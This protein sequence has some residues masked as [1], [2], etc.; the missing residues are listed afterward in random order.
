MLAL[1]TLALVAFAWVPVLTGNPRHS[2]FGA[3]SLSGFAAIAAVAG[4]RAVAALV[5]LT[6]WLVFAWRYRDGEAISTKGT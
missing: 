2:W 3:V 4:A 6:S 5:L 1:L